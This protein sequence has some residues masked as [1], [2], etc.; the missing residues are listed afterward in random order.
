MAQLI[1][2]AAVVAAGAGTLVARRVIAVAR[3]RGPWPEQSPGDDGVRRWHAVTVLV[4]PEELPPPD[5][6]PGPLGELGDAAEIR[7]HRAPGGKGVEIHARPAAGDQDL[8]DRTR[9]LRAALRRTKQVLETGAV[10]RP[11]R[12]GS[13]RPTV[14]NAPLRAATAHGMEAGRL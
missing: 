7:L 5:R 2:G 3:S 11:D 6:L 12:P 4:D 1:R 9:A 13:T 8:A 14:L 10:L